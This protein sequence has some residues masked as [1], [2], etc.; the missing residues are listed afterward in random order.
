MRT[1]AESH[2]STRWALQPTCHFSLERQRRHRQSKLPSKA[3]HIQ[4]LW[5]WLRNLPRCIRLKSS[6][7][8]GYLTSASGS[9]CTHMC[10]HKPVCPHTHIQESAYPHRWKW[11]IWYIQLKIKILWSLGASLKTFLH[12]FLASFSLLCPVFVIVVDWWPRHGFRK[13]CLLTLCLP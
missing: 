5:L 13:K 1:R 6:G 7:G 12:I 8:G 4:E 11:K 2:T 9:T 10:T 3:G